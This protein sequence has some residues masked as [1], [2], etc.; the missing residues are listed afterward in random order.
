MQIDLNGLM[1]TMLAA[2]GL[3]LFK[4]L[5]DSIEALNIRVAVIIQRVESH[6][7]RITRLE[8]SE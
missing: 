2:G 4:R 7:T 5:T 8:D 6:D 1:Q 3:Y